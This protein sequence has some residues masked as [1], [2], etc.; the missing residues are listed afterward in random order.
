[1][2]TEPFVPYTQTHTLVFRYCRNVELLRSALGKKEIRKMIIVA[3]RKA[4]FVIT[5]EDSGALDVQCRPFGRRYYGY[6]ATAILTSSDAA[7]HTYPER[8]Y[9]RTMQLKL[10]LCYLK[11]EAERSHTEHVESAMPIF[12]ALTGSEESTCT[13]AHPEYL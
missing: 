7:V 6:T 2:K 9:H 11:P 12:E 8:K 3:L 10:N 4:G 13:S 5:K 1:M